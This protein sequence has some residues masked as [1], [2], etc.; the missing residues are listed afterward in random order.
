M[1]IWGLGLMGTW[2]KFI[3]KN[4]MFGIAITMNFLRGNDD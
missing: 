1:Q 2:V 4:A 3:N